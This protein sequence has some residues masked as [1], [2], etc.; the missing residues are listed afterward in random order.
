MNPANKTLLTHIT[1][2]AVMTAGITA[3]IVFMGWGLNVMLSTYLPILAGAALITLTEHK[4]VYRG[5]WTGR[6]KDVIEDGIYMALIQIALPR[7]IMAG[8]S[9]YLLEILRESE[10]ISLKFW[11]HDWNT[12]SQVIL[13]LLSADFFRYWLHRASHEWAYLWRLHAVHHSPHKLYWFNVG[14]FHPIEKCL[15][16]LFDTIP[17]VLLGVGEQVFALYLVFYSING[18]FQH[19]NIELKL[20]PLNYLISGPELHRWHHSRL[21]EESNQNYGNNLILWDLLFGT[22]FLPETRQ[23]GELGLTNRS[24]PMRFLD[25]L[26]APFIKGLDKD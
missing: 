11:P 24:Y 23:V 1:Y 26:K 17:F 21:P 19:C 10:T 25:Q 16:M 14:R 6:K 3:H 20:G 5:Q 4:L 8:F 18:F 2:P 15:Q 7:I 12:G 13:M 9:L 22:W